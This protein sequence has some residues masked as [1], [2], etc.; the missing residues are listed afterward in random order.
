MTLPVERSTKR[1]RANRTSRLPQSDGPGG[2]RGG[3][4]HLPDLD[5]ARLPS[6]PLKELHALWRAYFGKAEPPKRRL[7][8]RELAYRFQ[9]RRVLPGAGA[10]PGGGGMDAA[11]RKLLNAAV[12]A[13][14]RS[15]EQRT[16][17]EPLEIDGSTSLPRPG[18][19][20][21]Q[22]ATPRPVAPTLPAA[23]T[24]VRV[25]RG[26]T[27]E[28]TVVQHGRGF[29]YR[30]TTYRSLSEIAKQITGTVWSGPR[31]FGVAPRPR[32]PRPRPR[33]LPGNPSSPKQEHPA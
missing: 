6:L 30:G 21:K 19:R 18:P 29:L 27:Y 16:K 11:T 26:R 8:V 2:G 4:S 12:R 24:L 33:N 28:V 14:L 10:G 15:V 5:L 25:W 3:G 20:P 31:F 13:A 1:P 23:A 32:N 7:L 9:E 17:G 22:Q